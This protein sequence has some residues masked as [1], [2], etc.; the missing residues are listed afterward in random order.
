MKK[1]YVVM[2]I[3]ILVVVTV[4]IP[5]SGAKSWMAVMAL[6]SLVSLTLL[7]LGLAKPKIIRQT[8]RKDV[9]VK[10]VTAFFVFIVLSAIANPEK[11]NN[12]SKVVKNTSTELNHSNNKPPENEISKPEPTRAKA[13]PINNTIE[14]VKS[15]KIPKVEIKEA[16]IDAEKTTSRKNIEAL[17]ITLKKHYRVNGSNSDYDVEL[18][19]NDICW[20]DKSCQI[21]A[22]TVQIQAIHHSVEAL[23]SSRVT[24]QYYQEVC[25][26]ILISLTGANKQ[27][28]EQQIPQ[29]F[30]HASQNGR[31][32]W[33]ALGVEITISPDSSGLLGCSFYKK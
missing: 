22:D 24:P 27:L 31:T 18:N 16:T 20:N 10:G 19:M 32:K 2:S 25:S 12:T 11:A 17:L 15:P 33:E 7:V 30:N 9:L 23:T 21:Y 14:K 29:Y 6:M 13:T 26:A 1:Q 8:T 28:V 5:D 3:I 4:F